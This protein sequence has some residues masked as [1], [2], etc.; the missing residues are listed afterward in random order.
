MFALCKHCGMMDLCTYLS[1]TGT[2]Q[3]QLAEVLG[4]SRSYLSQLVGGTKSPSL[5][6]AVRIER[7]TD[8]AVPVA[9]WVPDIPPTPAEDAA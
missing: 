3:T 8:G 4:V 9:S 5:E 2:K 7:A 1:T 6:L